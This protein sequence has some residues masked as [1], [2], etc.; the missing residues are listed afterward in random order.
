M[1]NESTPGT[2]PRA[3]AAH[4]SPT[5]TPRNAASSR[6]VCSSTHRGD[7]DDA[8]LELLQI[9]ASQQIRPTSQLE[10]TNLGVESH[11]MISRA[12][13]ILGQTEDAQ[14]V[15]TSAMGWA[16][17]PTILARSHPQL[18]ERSHRQ[19]T[20]TPAMCG[21]WVKLGGAQLGAA[22]L[23]HANCVVSKRPLPRRRTVLRSG[24]QGRRC[25]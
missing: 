4:T 18:V 13:S 11:K 5:T 2:H 3:S 9:S 22:C 21:V 17:G 6:A 20:D 23:C 10:C 8:A 15:Q 25:T 24:K 12:P 14:G 1:L 7:P 19:I 16:D